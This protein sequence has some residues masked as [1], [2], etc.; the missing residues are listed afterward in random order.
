VEDNSANVWGGV[1]Y[2]AV[3]ERYVGELEGA[4]GYSDIDTDLAHGFIVFNVVC[5]EGT[6]CTLFSSSF[7]SFFFPLLAEP[8]LLSSSSF[9]HAWTCSTRTHLFFPL[10]F[11]PSPCLLPSLWF[12]PGAHESG[13]AEKTSCSF[14]VRKMQRF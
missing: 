1:G 13:G 4:K 12:T 3:G 7:F 9:G 11:L 10:S 2:A 5:M 14:G 8:S 6:K